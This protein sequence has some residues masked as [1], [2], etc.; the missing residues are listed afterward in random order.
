MDGQIPTSLLR[1]AREKSGMSQGALAAELG[2]SGSVVSR[3]ES[4]D[5][6]DGKMAQRYLV[7]LK[8]ELAAEIIQFFTDR[9]RHIERPDFLHPER[10]VIWSAERALQALAEFE[11]DAQFDVILR[12]PLTQLRARIL[13][14]VDFVRHMEH[15]IAFVG[16]IGV[17]K[18]TAL[19]FVTNLVVGDSE[20]QKSVFPTGSGRT[21]VCEVAIKIAPAFGIAVDCLTEEQIRGLVTDLVN[22]L[23]CGKNGPPSE[24]ERV[25]RNMAD[26][27]RITI[28]AKNSSEKPATI[29]Y[30]KKLIESFS[31]VEGIIAEV[32]ARMKL[33]SRTETQLIL[34]KDTEGSMEWLAE[35]ISKI[36]YGQHP[37]FSVPQRITVL[38]PLEALRETPYLISVIDTKGVEGTTQ[39]P[40]LMAQIEDS[41]TVTV[42]CCK[43]PDAPG[44]TPLSI[45]R[46]VVETGSDA[47]DAERLCLLVLPREDEA[48]KIVDDSG[49]TP[50]TTEEG[51]A[52]REA[53][54]DQQFVTDGLVNIPVNFY[55]VGT[56][57]PEDVWLWLTS[58]IG[59]IRK[60]KVERIR[61]HVMAAEDLVINADVAKTRQ[62]RRTIAEAISKSAERFRELPNAIRPAHA[63]LVAEAKKTHQSS[64]AASVNRRG[65]W[66]NFPVAHI[67]GQGVRID[68]N[69]RTRDI[70]V[71]IDETI[72]GLKAN[73]SHL[74]DIAQFLENL[75]ESV[76]E[77]RKEFLSRTALAGRTLFAPHLIQASAMWSQCEARYGAGGGYR[78]NVAD[79]FQ[80]HFEEDQTAIAT[81]KKVEGQVVAIWSQIVIDPLE[82]AASFSDDE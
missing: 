30:L 50:T 59:A 7:A 49:T 19:S 32:M 66:E 74:A 65:V 10:D 71:R 29:D 73:F 12:D 26:V 4:S 43:F 82:A 69:L 41:R 20:K 48:L 8:T 54:I 64:V 14:E 40:D 27:R 68:A 23:V 31:D 25:I 44:N 53:Q 72:E 63:N 3:L 9:W 1:M 60:A 51:Y 17:G 37:K 21:T 70:F 35:N 39:R 38:L 61:R 52:I 57:E 75:K 36:N 28:R 56:D 42:L 15:G 62:A 67:L 18:T 45:M 46:E 2:V 79:I 47:L 55:Q 24:I 13:S 5:R 81:L 34:S 22:G 78:V 6:A 33:E 77:W 16:D 58:R 80:A 11:N 76:T